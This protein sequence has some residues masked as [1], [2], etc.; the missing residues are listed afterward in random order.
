MNLDAAAPR[1]A[2]VTVAHG[3]HD[4]LQL[5]HRSLGRSAVLLDDWIVVAM[6]DPWP[7]RWRT[8]FP[9]TPHVVE[10]DASDAGLPL[11]AA[12]NL[13]ARTALERGADL[14]VFLDVDCLASPGLALAYDVASRRPD[15]DGALL[16]GPVAYLPP[17][18]RGG[19]DLRS[20]AELGRPHR[21]RPAPPPGTVDLDP[22][23][24]R[25]F[26]SLSF[27]VTAATWGRIGGFDEAYVGYGGED[28]DFAQRAA[29]AGVPIAWVGGARAAHQHH[30]TQDPPVQHLHDIVRNAHVFHARWGW[31]PMEGWLDAFVQRGLV[32]AD[33]DGYRVASTGVSDA[34]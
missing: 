19:Y 6:D 23:G 34:L 8:G 18:P 1:I 30:P 28:T 33:D 10:T 15:C 4:H 16:C 2:V 12:R 21:S 29:A 9:P 26:W 25:L 24:H 31:W 14:L 17:A 20:V 11:A 27:A 5:Q 3:R 32:H 13:G 22:H 7:A